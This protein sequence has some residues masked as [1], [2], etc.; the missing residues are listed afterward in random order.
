M[1]AVMHHL[2]L[3]CAVTV[4]HPNGS[5]QICCETESIKICKFHAK[6]VKDRED[7]DSEKER[8]PNRSNTQREVS[9]ETE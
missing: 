7:D 6:C 2:A 5:C 8:R 3:V 4:L 1:R 9:N